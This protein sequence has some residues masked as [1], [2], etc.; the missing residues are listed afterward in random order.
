M[1]FNKF[2]IFSWLFGLYSIF[3]KF[4]F[5]IGYLHFVCENSR[6]VSNRIHYGAIVFHFIEIVRD[7][8]TARL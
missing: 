4:D 7:I 8:E 6:L 2:V 1:I 3:E 5:R